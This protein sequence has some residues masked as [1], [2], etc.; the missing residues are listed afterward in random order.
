MRMN[1]KSNTDWIIEIKQALEKKNIGQTELQK[2]LEE[3]GHPIAKTTIQRL[4]KERSEYEDSFRYKDTI[5][6]IA[7][8]VL[9]NKP[10]E[11]PVA[12]LKE[13]V[14]YL[15]KKIEELCDTASKGITFMRSQIDLKDNR[16]ERKDAWVQQLM[17]ENK[18]LNEEVCR[19]LDKC[20]NCDKK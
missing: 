3:Y 15:T 1:L 5:Q 18:R 13:R 11:D 9:D 7:E 12:E 10:E 8:L 14:D 19:L 2:M 4:Y 6:P 17:D 16:M 20:N